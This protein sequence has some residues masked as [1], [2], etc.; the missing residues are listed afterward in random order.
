MSKVFRAIM[1]RCIEDLDKKSDVNWPQGLAS[2]E[3]RRDYR[4]KLAGRNWN[5]FSRATLN[6]TKAVV[7]YLARYTSRIAISNQ[8]IKAVDEEQRTVTIEY[9]DYRD[10]EQSKQMTLPGA[11][12]LR[13][14]SRHL[15]PKGFRRVRYYGLLAGA[16]GRYRTLHGAPQEA[17]SEK[18]VERTRPACQMC[19]CS[20]WNY[21]RSQ[22]CPG[23][24][25]SDHMKIVKPLIEQGIG[26]FSLYPADT[27]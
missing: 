11:V 21:H 25:P 3:A 12:F 9:K 6:N 4:L 26:R 20:E 18:A 14:L 2:I 17:I 1:L 22:Y 8:R 7:R 13:R 15:V 16:K 24:K 5:I 10:K 27:G 23:V 19:G